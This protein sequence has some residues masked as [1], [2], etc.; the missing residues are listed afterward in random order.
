MANTYDIYSGTFRNLVT[1]KMELF[2]TV[3]NSWEQFIYYRKELHFRGAKVPGSTSISH[4]LNLC[5]PQTIN[6]GLSNNNPIR[7]FWDIESNVGIK[8]FFTSLVF[9]YFFGIYSLICLQVCH[10]ECSIF[11]VQLW[12]LL[13]FL[14][15]FPC[16]MAAS[17]FSCI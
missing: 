4:P 1:F 7:Q 2:V 13:S 5:I 8:Y 3:F 6:M 14:L 17:N 16:C 12:F 15:L 10:I 11:Y 9:Q